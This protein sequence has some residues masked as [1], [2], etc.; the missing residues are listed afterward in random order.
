MGAAVKSHPIG[1]EASHSAT[2]AGPL[3]TNGFQVVLP[4]A[5]EAIVRDLADPSEVK[6]ERERLEGFWFVHWTGGKLYHLRLSAGGPNVDGQQQTI[7]TSEHPWLLRARLEDAIGSALQSYIPIRKRPFTF[8]AQKSEL[9]KKAAAAADIAHE[10]L[11]TFKAQAGSISTP[12]FTSMPAISKPRVRPPA[13]QKRS[14]AEI[15]R[16][17]FLRRTFSVSFFLAPCIRSLCAC[18]FRRFAFDAF[19]DQSFIFLDGENDHDRAAMFL[20]RDWL[21][22]RCID[23]SAEFVF[24][25]LR[26]HSF[27][28]TESVRAILAIM[29]I[30]AGHRKRAVVRNGTKAELVHG[31]VAGSIPLEGQSDIP[32]EPT[33]PR[34]ER[35]A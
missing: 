6:A 14:I 31:N 20:D 21:R 11:D 22:A 27:Q 13:P 1:D 8:L 26:R 35:R 23:Q 4:E 2:E 16:C 5:V 34:H 12:I 3:V 24:G 19:G 9:I 15:P 33:C 28:S 32:S 17:N 25:V 7:R 29:S 18:T 30:T 10:L